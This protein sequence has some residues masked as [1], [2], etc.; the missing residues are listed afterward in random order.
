MEKSGY[1]WE[2]GRPP[3]VLRVHSL[4]KHDVL[5]TYLVR[6]LKV[7]AANPKIDRF[8][9]TLVDGFSG[10]GLYLHETSRKEV[11]G[12]PLIFLSATRDAEA[13][14]NLGRKKNFTLD[15]HYIFIEKQLQTLEYLRRLLTDRGHGRLLDNRVRL[16]HGAFIDKVQDIIRFILNKGRTGRAIFL[17]DQYGYKDVPFP[18]LKQLFSALPNAEVILTFAVDAL[19]DYLSDS[20]RSEHTVANI[21]LGSLDARDFA[22]LKGASDRRYFIQ[23]RLSPIMHKES[24]ASFFTPFF[25]VSRESNR[26][27]WLVHLSMHA[28]ARD[29]MAKLHWELH[30]Y[31][32]HN[33]GAG[34]H[35]VGYDPNKDDELSGQFGFEDFNFDVPVRG[36]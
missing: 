33:G 31:F 3:P 30:N 2:I 29:E 23:S 26:D 4:A 15:A 5:R 6:Y 36:A 12:S 17:L 18:L 28:R 10:G 20:T 13:E 11:E 1:E 24:G 9:L 19:I 21:G 16:L 14:I 8:R 32:R 34:L 22:K 25:I 7:L 35:M 27:Y